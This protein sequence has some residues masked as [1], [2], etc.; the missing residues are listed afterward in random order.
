MRK[1]TSKVVKV[2]FVP[3]HMGQL[4]PHVKVERLK[5]GPNHIR[6]IVLPD[7]KTLL[8]MGLH[9]HDRVVL[10]TSA[11]GEV[12]IAEVDPAH[13]SPYDAKLVP[14]TECPNCKAKLVRQGRHLY[15]SEPD[16]CE[17]VMFSR[18][19]RFI[20]EQGMEIERLSDYQL[21]VLSESK[22]LKRAS[23]LMQ[24]DKLSHRLLM[25]PSTSKELVDF[26]RLMIE[27]AVQL[28]THRVLYAL[29]V[30]DLSPD[31]CERLCEG[32]SLLTVSKLTIE[33]LKPYLPT[34][35][36][37]RLF[38]HYFQRNPANWKRDYENLKHLNCMNN[39]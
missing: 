11:H 22:L 38:T 17:G 39:P 32:K 35:E 15:C 14:P 36:Q 20:G 30:A 2:E 8:T 10:K 27:S 25:I 26:I 34:E 16:T 31:T 4:Q 19:H 21:R 28:P 5:S 24:L 33:E 37:L 1:H 9:H 6:V 7:V 13:R 12:E 29:G 23:D 3:N 18:L